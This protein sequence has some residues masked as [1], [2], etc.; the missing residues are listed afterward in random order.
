MDLDLSV[1]L[2]KGKM[3][4]ELHFNT[5]NQPQIG[6]GNSSHLSPPCKPFHKMLKRKI[7]SIGCEAN[8][9]ETDS[10]LPPNV[11]IGVIDSAPVKELDLPM[12][13]DGSAAVVNN[14][15]RIFNR[16]ERH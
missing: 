2:G 13:A 11:E 10:V 12:L 5:R 4:Q 7:E 14:Q 1:E 6:E 3:E 8:A 15:C 16:N 9:E